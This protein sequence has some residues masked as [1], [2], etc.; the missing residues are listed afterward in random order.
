MKKV[1]KIVEVEMFDKEGYLLFN[2][3]LDLKTIKGLAQIKKINE[4]QDSY[5]AMSNLYKAL[6]EVMTKVAKNNNIE[7]GYI[8][9]YNDYSNDKIKY[10][11]N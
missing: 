7:G 9:I 8:I 5:C 10:H 2:R 6:F 3:K 1:K 4:L 11:I